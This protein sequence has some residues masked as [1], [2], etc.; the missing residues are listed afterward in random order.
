MCTKRLFFLLAT[1]VFLVSCDDGSNN[2]NNN[3]YNNH[4]NNINNN[5]NNTNNTTQPVIYSVTPGRGPLAGGTEVMIYGDR[6][7]ADAAVYFGAQAAARVD[8]ISASQLAVTTPAAAQAGAV[9]VRVVQ[10]GGEAVLAG[11]FTY[12]DAAVVNIAWCIFQSPASTTT[13]LQVTTEA[14]Y[15]RVFAE[16][17]TQGVGRGAGITAQV[18]FGARGSDPRTDASWVWTTALFSGDVDDGANDEYVGNLLPSTAGEYDMAF[19]FSGGGAWVYCD[20]DGTDNGYSAVAAAHLTVTDNTEPM[21]DWCTLQYPPTLSGG[22]GVPL[23][24]IYGR[25]YKAGVTPGAGQGA[26]IVAQLGYGPLGT[27]PATDPGWQWV[28]AAYNTDVDQGSNDEYQARITLSQPGKYAYAYR[29]TYRGGPPLYCDLDGSA[30]GYQPDAAGVANVSGTPVDT[31]IDWCNFQ[32]PDQTAS[33]AGQPTTLLFGRVYINGVTVGAGQGPGVTAQV[34]YGPPGTDPASSG[35]WNWVDASYNV[36]VDGVT[37]GDRAND[38]YMGTLT[39][40]AAGTYDMAYR[41]S[42][43]GGTTWTYCDRD[44]SPNGYSPAQA[45]QLTVTAQPVS[46]VDWCVFQAPTTTQNWLAGAPSPNLYGRV[47][48]A[49]VTDGPGQGPGITAEFGYGPYGSDPSAGGWTWSPGTYGSSVDGL[50]P[51]GLANDE[52]VGGL[53][54]A[55]AGRYSMAVRFS[56]DGGTS[57]T[58]CDKDGSQ[59]GLQTSQLVEVNVTPSSSFALLSISPDRGP[60]SGGQTVTLTGAGFSAGMTVS[61][62]GAACTGLQVV[63]ATQATCITPAHDRPEPA[64]VT[65]TLGTD[66]SGLPDAYRYIP[67]MTPQMDGQLSE[68][69]AAY[70]VSVNAVAT[71]WGADNALH[72][73]YFA[74]DD[75]RMYFAIDG[76]TSLGNAFILYIDSDA[77][78]GTGIRNGTALNDNAGELDNCIAGNF[79]VTEATFGAEWAVGTK[80]MTHKTLGSYSD[81]AGLRNIAINPNDFA[82]YDAEV[83]QT[84]TGVIEISLP[85]NLFGFETGTHTMAVF[86]LISDWSGL[87]Y[88]NQSF[89]PG[90]NGATLPGTLSITIYK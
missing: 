3:P 62:G 84:G 55:S 20:T 21:P 87:S 14:L 4:L 35:S 74:Y 76:G 52:Y 81:L 44:G 40:A 23:G 48:V 82:W 59:N 88:S 63:N 86:A 90:I 16:G 25:V 70:V 71:D 10:T 46:T 78:A 34:G 9:D 73:L 56:R 58:Y 8:R 33:V 31:A 19:R 13:P 45:A 27:N 53:A 17:V 51:G 38:E 42:R 72:Q 32:Y 83:I 41:F 5:N 79:I 6:F 22:L 69:S 47:Y 36:D 64:S 68:W 75:A 11:A 89:P 57:W 30:N 80:N 50:I 49:G 39:V 54:I 37:P 43:D 65:A 7:A 1:L 61:I 26:E 60:L 24:P 18:G 15:G 12:E 85:L 77:G 67:Y 29:F 28:D 66:S 2:N